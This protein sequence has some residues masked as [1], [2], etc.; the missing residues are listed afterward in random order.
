MKNA[1]VYRPYIRKK[2]AEYGL[3]QC[4]E[5]LPVI[6]SGYNTYARSKSGA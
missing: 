5:F 4:L 6:E 1:A 3:P 2:L